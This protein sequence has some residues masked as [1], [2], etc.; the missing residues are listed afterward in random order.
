MRE[1]NR[2]A[3]MLL[4]LLP[5]ALFQVKFGRT[6]LARALGLGAGFLILSGV[7]LTYSR[8]AFLTLAALVALCAI[9]GYVRPSR[10]V[11]AVV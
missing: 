4:V 11:V 2:F 3:Q 8:G 7:L 10:I 5:L 6:G 9:L 1:P